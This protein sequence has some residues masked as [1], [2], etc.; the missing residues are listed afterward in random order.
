MKSRKQKL[1][2]SVNVLSEQRYLYDKF[3]KKDEEKNDIP[4]LQVSLIEG[5]FSKYKVNL[6]QNDILK[7]IMTDEILQKLNLKRE[8]ASRGSAMMDVDKVT[9]E[10]LKNI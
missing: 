10:Q 5:R 2:V 4:K 3:L 9:S 8:Y 1:M 7:D 6:F